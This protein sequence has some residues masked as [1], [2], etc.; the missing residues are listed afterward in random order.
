MK[1]Y[2]EALSWAVNESMNMPNPDAHPGKF[3]EWAEDIC[4]IIGAIYDRD[5][6]DVADDLREQL[7]LIDD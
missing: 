5:F 7:D 4:G 1:S 3:I 6:D 2:R